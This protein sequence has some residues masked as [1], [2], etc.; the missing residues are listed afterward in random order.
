M[1]MLLL[2]CDAK[3]PSS[4]AVTATTPATP[5]SLLSSA[6]IAASTPA[7][8]TSVLPMPDRAVPVA[9]YTELNVDPDGMALNYIIVARS[10]NQLSHEE[11][12]RHLSAAYASE[13]DA[14]KRQDLAKL[15]TPR[16]EALLNQYRNQNYFSLPL[17][18]FSQQ[19]LGV[20][21]VGVSQYNFKTKSFPLTSYGHGCWNS[22]LRN[23][24]GATL[25]IAASDL[26][27]GLPVAD[28]AQA[29]LIEA[30]RAEN[31]LAIQG[32]LYVFIPKAENDIA[33]A[34][35]SRAHIELVNTRTNTPLGKFDL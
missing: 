3:K 4:D 15:E 5:S 25:K 19:T 1:G 21:T 8:V 34:V 33:L 26:P 35:A 20:T 30:A 29:K 22:T 14:F 17:S 27:C 12:L 16:I 13:N 6:K 2:G 23:R 28:E 31:A 7:L 11:K 9:S 18:A 24:S 10:K 32:T